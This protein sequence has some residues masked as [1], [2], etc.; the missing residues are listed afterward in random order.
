MVKIFELEKGISSL[1]RPQLVLLLNFLKIGHDV[2]FIAHV[3]EALAQVF[4]SNPT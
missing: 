2:C 4:G 3:V 1:P